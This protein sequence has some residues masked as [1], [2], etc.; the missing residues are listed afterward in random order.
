[1]ITENPYLKELRADV[2]MRLA[3]KDASPVLLNNVWDLAYGFSQGSNA[4]E[5]NYIFIMGRVLDVVREKE[6]QDEWF[7]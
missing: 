6:K 7:Y 4:L 1:M 5:S 3:P 2:E